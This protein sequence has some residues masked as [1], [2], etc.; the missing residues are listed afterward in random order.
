M[1]TRKL[2]VT[3]KAFIEQ[4]SDYEGTLRFDFLAPGYGHTLGNSLRRV[5]LSSLEGY[6]ITGIKLPEGVYHEFGTIPGVLENISEIILN[7]KKIRFKKT[8]AS[9]Q[10]K[11]IISFK[12]KVIFKAGDLANVSSHFK[13]LN[14]DLTIC[15]MDESANFEL[16]LKIEKGEGYVPAEEYKNTSQIIGHIPID[17]IFTPIKNVEYKVESTLVGEKIDYCEKVIMKIKTDGSITPKKALESAASK[18]IDHFS[19]FI[20]KGIL[21]EE[22]D[23]L[24]EPVIDQKII[25]M[26]KK[27]LKPLHDLGLGART[28]NCL[29]SN[30]VKNL[31][32]IVQ[33][34]FPKLMQF[35]NFGKISMTEVEELLAKEGLSLGMDIS[36]YRLNEEQAF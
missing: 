35:R 5:L 9:Q 7:L 12:N 25:F 32:D 36:A 4:T 6:A 19:L 13:I 20:D 22:K 29:K 8:G 24:E 26:R 34:T 10:E 30:N 31:G 21:M 28:F 3:P 16:Q 18:L 17:A 33:L 14:P 27:L 1:S 23:V 11:L 2:E 15:T